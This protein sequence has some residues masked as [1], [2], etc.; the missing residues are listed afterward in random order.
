MM[1]TNFGMWGVGWIGMA[2]VWGLLIWLV[3]RLIDRSNTS[4]SA[5]APIDILKKRLARGDIDQEKYRQ[6]K[7]DLSD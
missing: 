3:W 5:D 1:Y 6:L 2:L 7:K 4:V